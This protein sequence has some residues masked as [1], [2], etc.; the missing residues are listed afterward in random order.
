[1]RLV[2]CFVK[3]LAYT[4]YVVGISGDNPVTLDRVTD[5]IHRLLEESAKMADL[6]GFHQKEYNEARFAVCAWIDEAILCS[7]W[8]ERDMWM[9]RLLQ[10]SLYSTIRAGEE[11]YGRMDTLGDADRQVRDVYYHCLALGFKGRYF[12]PD[13]ENELVRIKQM[14]Y[15]ELRGENSMHMAGSLMG[16]FPE[17]Y[18]NNPIPRR[19][20]LPRIALSYVTLSMI[21]APLVFLVL[22]YLSYSNLLDG[23]AANLNMLE[24]K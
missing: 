15:A 19:R 13:M 7:S 17:S 23:T 24:I 22:T 10:R 2:D 6:A 4:A 5:V 1:M 21:L 20:N 3:P 8:S 16:F 18:P 12:S 9:G 14:E 11:F